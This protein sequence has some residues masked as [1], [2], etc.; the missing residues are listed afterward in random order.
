MAKATVTPQ[1]IKVLPYMESLQVSFAEQLVEEKQYHAQ[2][3]KS[4]W[5]ISIAKSK[6]EVALAKRHLQNAYNEAH[7]Q[8]IVDYTNQVESL[9]RGLKLAQEAFVLLFPA[10][11]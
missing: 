4:N 2:E 3:Q 1:G 9:E 7:L 6:K 5:E 10:A 8:N 11:E